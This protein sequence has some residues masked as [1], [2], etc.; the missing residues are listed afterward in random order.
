M[1][2]RKPSKKRA[3]INKPNDIK[4]KRSSKQWLETNQVYFETIMNVIL[5]LM[6]LIV[7]IVVAIFSL[8]YEKN[9]LE[10]QKQ[11][12]SIA[13]QLNMPVFNVIKDYTESDICVSIIN[14]GGNIT[15]G[16]LHAETKLEIIVLD[17]NYKTK[18]IIVLD[19]THLFNTSY[20]FYNVQTKSFTISKK[21]EPATTFELQNYLNEQLHRDYDAYY[22]TII[23]DDYINIQYNDF[24]GLSHNEW[25]W[26]FGGE[27]FNVSQI[28]PDRHD[29]FNI[30]TMTIEE[31]YDKIKNNLDDVLNT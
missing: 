9:A 10:I 30:D 29:H 18:A 25:Y 15:N 24:Q 5:A 7:S 14:S 19:D 21:G 23:L 20:S 27:L 8:S 26:L 3:Q 2:K 1:K 28:V 11:Q 13:N 4:Q 16:Y 12:A 6:G 22:F 31:I 17:T